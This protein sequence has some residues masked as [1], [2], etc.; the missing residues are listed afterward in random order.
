[1]K[2]SENQAQ[3]V[4]TQP[5]TQ[6]LCVVL[7]LARPLCGPRGVVHPNRKFEAKLESYKLILVFFTHAKSAHESTSGPILPCV[8]N[9]V[10]SLYK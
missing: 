1:M 4:S 3:A 8:I 5:R 7:W 2:T 10:I 9:D 6:A